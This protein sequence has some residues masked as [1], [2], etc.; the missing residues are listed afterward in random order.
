LRKYD[1][2]IQFDK[3]QVSKILAM[4]ANNTRCQIEIWSVLGTK[5]KMRFVPKCIRARTIS[6][7][8]ESK[9]KLVYWD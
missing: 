9:K 3:C 5:I 6:K 4:L 1:N 2:C 8:P 7:I